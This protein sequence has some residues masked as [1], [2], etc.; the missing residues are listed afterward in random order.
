MLISY[1][2]VFL[3]TFVEKGLVFSL[4][5]HLNK[6]V[7]IERVGKYTQTGVGTV[8]EDKLAG[9]E[10]R[11]YSLETELGSSVFKGHL[12]NSHPAPHIQ[13]PFVQTPKQRMNLKDRRNNTGLIVII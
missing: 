3:A 2:L 13:A 4:S 12:S 1:R 8:N 11:D 6:K 9:L 10:F 5:I 7:F